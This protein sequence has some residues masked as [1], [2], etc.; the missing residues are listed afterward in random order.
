MNQSP[1]IEHSLFQC[2]SCK[3]KISSFGVRF[4]RLEGTNAVNVHR[5][6]KKFLSVVKITMLSAHAKM[7][8]VTCILENLLSMTRYSFCQAILSD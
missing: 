7:A 8:D 2:T 6:G 5:R 4:D 1:R 3:D